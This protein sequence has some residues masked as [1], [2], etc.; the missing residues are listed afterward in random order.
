[1]DGWKIALTSAENRE[2]CFIL[3]GGKKPPRPFGGINLCEFILFDCDN[4]PGIFNKVN[5]KWVD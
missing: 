2:L 1:M 3:G 5:N 4:I